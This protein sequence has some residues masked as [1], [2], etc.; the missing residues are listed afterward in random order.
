MATAQ[1]EGYGLGSDVQPTH[2]TQPSVSSLILNTSKFTSS[3]LEETFSDLK[4]DDTDHLLYRFSKEEAVV[5]LT[6]IP[7][8]VTSLFIENHA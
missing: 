3:Q 6:C 8:A 5:A 4:K 2:L 7:V 1:G